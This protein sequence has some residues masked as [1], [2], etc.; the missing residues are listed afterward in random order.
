[1]TRDPLGSRLTRPALAFN[2]DRCC[3][4]SKLRTACGS[5]TRAVTA[6][7][8]GATSEWID[9]APPLT[10]TAPAPD[11]MK[12][13]MSAAPAPVLVSVDDAPLVN[14]PANN[15]DPLLTSITPSL[16]ITAYANVPLPR[17]RPPLLR[18]RLVGPRSDPPA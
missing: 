8:A 11:E 14:G 12:V 10:A 2:A 7:P 3:V 15:N 5:L 9:S 4:V 18:T 6:C 1:M 17:M 16:V 13:G